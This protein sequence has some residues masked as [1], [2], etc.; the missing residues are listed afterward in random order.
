MQIYFINYWKHARVSLCVRMI[1][2]MDSVMLGMKKKSNPNIF[3]I[4]T[5]LF[6]QIHA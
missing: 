5:V 6:M 1:V 4:I 3:F 2:N